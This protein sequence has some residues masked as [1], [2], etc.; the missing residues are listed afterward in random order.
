MCIFFAVI[1]AI[2][3]P[4][5]S[6]NKYEFP[7]YRIILDP[8]HGGVAMRPT[9]IHGDRFDPVTGRYLDMFREGASLGRLHERDIVYSIVKKAEKLL[10]LCAPYG[11]NRAFDEILDKYAAE[12]PDRIN[13]ITYVSRDSSINEEIAE[14]MEDPNAGYRLFDYPGKDGSL[15]PGRLSKMNSLKPHLVVSIHLAEY[16]PREYKGM[17]PVIAAPYSVLD[18]GRRYLNGERGVR[19]AIG[20]RIIDDWFCQGSDRSNFQWFLNDVSM[21]FTGYSLK[22]GTEEPD[23]FRGYRYNM[24]DW[25]YRDFDGWEY[26]GRNHPANTRYAK[27]VKEFVPDGIYW[28]REGSKYEKFRREGGPEGF[29]GDNAY[30]SY[31]IIRYMLY[32][33]YKNSNRRIRHRAGKSYVNV[34]IIPLQVN[35]INAYLELGYLRRA[36]DRHIMTRRQD[37][38]AEGLAVGVYSLFS[39]MKLKTDDFPEIPRGKRI[40]LERYRVSD[41]RTYFDAVV[42]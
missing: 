42:E 26:I 33:L 35:A 8:G 1:A 9:D 38:I 21:Y 15:Q 2:S 5:T 14:T 16:G 30:A 32:S 23:E 6:T 17:S 10:K 13:L 11:N 28:V 25:G 7:T 3:I 24:V 19:K 18:L 12:V 29:G 37:D 4:L 36:A 31:E 34:W 27:R 20:S 22:R 41:D 39:G 40:D